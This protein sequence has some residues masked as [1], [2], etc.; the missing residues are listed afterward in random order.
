MRFAGSHPLLSTATL[1]KS[2]FS[3]FRYSFAVF[4]GLLR[5]DS[6][7]RLAAQFVAPKFNNKLIP[8]ICVQERERPW[9]WLYQGEPVARNLPSLCTSRAAMDEEGSVPWLSEKINYL[10]QMYSR[11]HHSALFTRAIWDL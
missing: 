6:K 8:I 5:V 7:C 1:S 2:P 3:A 9:P 10:F 11:L 4:L